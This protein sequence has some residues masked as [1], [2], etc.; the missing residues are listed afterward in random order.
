V[1]ADGRYRFVV[2]GDSRSNPDLWFNIVKHIN[3]LVPKPDFVINTGDIVRHGY[4]SEY[5]EYFIPAF[6]K[7]SIPFFVVIGNHDDGD[8]GTAVEYKTLFGEN[9]L[10]YFFDYGNRRFIM[11]DNVSAVRPYHETLAWLERTLSETPQGFSILVA[12]HKPIANIEKWAYHSW[13]PENSQVF[14]DLMTEYDVDD[15]FF[16]HIHAYSTAEHAGVSYTISGG[17][18]AGLHDRFG[19]QGNV[20]HYVICDV[21]SDGRIEQ[22]VVRFHQLQ[23]EL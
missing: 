19:P 10:N 11:I 14:A 20:H 12:A 23:T 15:V 4:T 21:L 9:S 3:Q 1:R 2:I 8:E 7:M 22:Q 13:D 18:G 5:L 16:G 6:S 17:G